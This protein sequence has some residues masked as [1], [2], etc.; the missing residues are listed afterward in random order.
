MLCTRPGLTMSG[1][2]VRKADFEMSNR[3]NSGARVE[4]SMQEQDEWEGKGW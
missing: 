2:V 1:A 4:L 3:D